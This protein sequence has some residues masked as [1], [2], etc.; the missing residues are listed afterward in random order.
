LS[1]FDAQKRKTGI[2][3]SGFCFQ[4]FFGIAK[5]D[6]HEL[7]LGT[8]QLLNPGFDLLEFAVVGVGYRPGNDQWRSGFV[9]QDTIHLINDGIVE[10]SLHHLFRSSGHIVAQI[11]EA[12]FVVGAVGDVAGVLLP[13]LLRSHGVEN[14]TYREIMKSKNRVHPLLVSLGKVVIDGHDVYAPAGKCIEKDREC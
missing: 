6:G 9:N 7:L 12:E 11:V 5:S 13:S 3:V 1:S 10:V 2:S 8:Y 4:E 14:N